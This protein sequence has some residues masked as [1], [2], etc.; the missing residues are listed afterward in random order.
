MIIGAV[1]RGMCLVCCSV[2]FRARSNHTSRHP[3]GLVPYPAH[4]ADYRIA[5]VA[6]D[7]A[8]AGTRA[9]SLRPDWGIRGR[10]A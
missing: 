2:V 10:E 8:L 6:S 4:I 9:S 5:V 3:F 7:I 1:T